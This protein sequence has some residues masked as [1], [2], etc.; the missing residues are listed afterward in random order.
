MLLHLDVQLALI[1]FVVNTEW[2]LWINVLGRRLIPGQIQPNSPLVSAFL[3]LQVIV[4]LL[5]S[6]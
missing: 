2:V 3:S 5:L 4:L 1:E 6:D